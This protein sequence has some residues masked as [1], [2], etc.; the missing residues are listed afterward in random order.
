MKEYLAKN[1]QHCPPYETWNGKPEPHSEVPARMD[2]IEKALLD[3]PGQIIYPNQFKP[4]PR[5]LIPDIHDLSYLSFLA[6]TL[7]LETE[8]YRYP[9][10]FPY[11][12]TDQFSNQPNAMLGY[13]ST[14]LYTP[15]NNKVLEYAVL[16]ASAAYNSAL[17]VLEGDRSSYALSRPPGHHAGFD[18][19][20]GYCYLNNAA[21][22]ARTLSGANYQKRV[23]ILDIDFHHGNG[24]EDIFKKI[25]SDLPDS[26]IGVL[27]ISIHADPNEK[28]PYFSGQKTIKETPLSQ[29]INYPLPLGTTNQEYQKTLYQ[30]LDRVCLF[31]PEYLVIPVGFDTHEQDP[32]GGFKLTT[33]YY[34]QI[35]SEIMSL[36]KPTVFIQEGGYN[37]DTIGANLT[38]FIEGIEG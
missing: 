28:F 7:K 17:A 2:M 16:S 15:I 14:D 38:S 18:F 27:H 21:L 33:E 5:N 37:L 26:Q 36:E 1:L 12:R 19:M 29:G 23:A 4:I 13:Y 35:A 6:N 24:T 31:N 25:Q 30:A 10:V 20:G 11:R 32:I 34:R 8:D 22:A 9:S 3:L